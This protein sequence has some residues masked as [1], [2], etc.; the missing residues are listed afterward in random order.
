[1]GTVVDWCSY[2]AAKYA[3]EHWHYSGT[4][5]AG[6]TVKLGVWEDGQFVGV[7]VFCLGSNRFSGQNFGVRSTEVCELGRV[8]LREHQST[9]S[10]ILSRSLSK[11][12]D[13]SPDLRLVVSYADPLHGH[14]GGIYQ[15]ANWVYVGSENTDT[16][17]RSYR[18]TRTGRVIGWRTMAAI[19]VSMP[20]CS[21]N[22]E[23]ARKAGFE[24]LPL[25]QKHKY[26]YPLDRAMRCQIMQL[27]RPYPRPAG[28]VHDGA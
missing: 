22:L 17:C 11:L 6:K 5:P 12:R 23:G 26:L 3:I 24:P 25:Y 14:H 9:V 16:R 4:L 28:E 15:A 1:M 8:A 20:D 10:H 13:Q 19:L 21:C 2:Q 7:V 27:A 18:E